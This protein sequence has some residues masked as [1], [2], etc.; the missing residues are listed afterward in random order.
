MHRTSLGEEEMD[1]SED[2]VA[3]VEEK[4]KKV[5]RWTARWVEGFEKA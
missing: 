3:L 5:A 1:V 4:A 2:E